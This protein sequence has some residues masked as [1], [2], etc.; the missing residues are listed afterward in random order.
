MARSIE[1]KYQQALEPIAIVLG[2][3]DDSLQEMSLEDLRELELACC[4][5]TT[6]N[7]WCYTYKAAKHIRQELSRLIAL[8][9]KNEQPAST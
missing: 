3:I 1:K 9:E 8:A 6:T 7:C 5:V 4:A 2:G